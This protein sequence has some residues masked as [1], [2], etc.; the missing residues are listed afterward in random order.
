MGV[1]KDRARCPKSRQTPQRRPFA[2][3]LDDHFLSGKVGG[4]VDMSQQEKY[5][6]FVPP[7]QPAP[8]AQKNPSELVPVPNTAPL[9]QRVEVEGRVYEIVQVQPQAVTHQPAQPHYIQ[10]RPML[11]SSIWDDPNT[12]IIAGVALVVGTGCLTWLVM[13]AFAPAPV[14]VVA[15][16]P[17]PQTVIVQPPQPQT[18]PY[19]RRECRPAGMF[20]WGSDCFEERGYQ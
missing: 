18:K 16:A 5:F 13:R 1:F 6:G 4:E 11:R 17:Q 8:E 2:Y 19:S 14:P 15:P 10:P 12:V 20:G 3:L 7:S 9:V